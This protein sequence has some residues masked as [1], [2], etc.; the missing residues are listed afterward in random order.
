MM[1]K[2]VLLLL[3]LV[4]FF[5]LHDSVNAI[6]SD[7]DST[8]KPMTTKEAYESN[9][10]TS[11]KK[12][13]REFEKNSKLEVKL[14]QNIPFKVKHKFGKV[15]SDS[16]LTLQYIG[17]CFKD[18]VL[19]V[20]VSQ[21]K[22]GKFNGD[23]YKLKNGTEVLIQENSNPNFHFPTILTFKKD[24]LYYDFMLLYQDKDLEKQKIIEI[25]ETLN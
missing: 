6:N 25:V 18:N 9:G 21:N 20:T 24:N 7:K 3:G 22:L 2:L 23:V 5:S 11:L 14:P 4:I 13:T 8:K 16:R 1:R 17:E 15:E 10:Y 12:A 19:T